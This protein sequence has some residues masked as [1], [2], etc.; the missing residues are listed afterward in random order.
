[1]AKQNSIHTSTTATGPRGLSRRAMLSLIPAGLFARWCRAFAALTG[2]PTIASRDAEGAPSGKR[3][4]YR[5]VPSGVAYK[6]GPNRVARVGPES[7]VYTY[8]SY[9]EDGRII[10]HECMSAEP[11]SPPITQP[12]NWVDATLE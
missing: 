1:M 6:I 4:T 11:D 2:A 9:D 3:I 7:Y 5:Y 12:S 8:R 10:V